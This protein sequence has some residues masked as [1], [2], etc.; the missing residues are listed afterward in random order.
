MPERFWE[1]L[2]GGASDIVWAFKSLFGFRS[3][4]GCIL[5][6][7]GDTLSRMFQSPTNTPGNKEN[8]ET[9]LTNAV[10]TEFP[11]AFTNIAL[12][13]QQD[14]FLKPIIEQLAQGIKSEKYVLSK[15]VL[16]H[17]I[18]NGKELRIIAPDMINPMLM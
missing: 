18:R 9:A 10:I 3:R 5:D 7:A 1:P 16:C 4:V 11:L 12:Y 17:K 6:P 14:P 8:P 2:G 13:Q 15:S